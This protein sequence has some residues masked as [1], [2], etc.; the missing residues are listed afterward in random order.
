MDELRGVYVVLVTPLDSQRNVDADGLRGNVDWLIREGVDGIVALGSTGEFAS[1]DA[2]SRRVVV[3]T[4]VDSARGRVP[5]MVGTGAETTE[6]TIENTREAQR[7]GATSVLVIPP[8][9]YTP[10]PEELVDHYVSVAEASELPLMVYNNPFTS[11]VDIKPD[12]LSLIAKHERV[13]AVK[14]SSGNIRRITEIRSRTCDSIAVFCGWEDMAYESFVV[15]ATGWICV[16][17]NIVPRFCVE[18]FRWAGDMGSKERARELYGKMLPFLRYLEYRGRTQQA[19][20]YALD[21]LGLAGGRCM[22]PKAPL[23]S[24]E[25]EEIRGILYELGV[26]LSA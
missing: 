16:A 24:Q 6:A 3:R 10:S 26:S 25:V 12:A 5:V 20:K 2:E 22:T 8:W 9:Y 11:K 15:G 19:L 1:L 23:T 13:V 17:G 18:L 7:L 14:E 21:H 4:V